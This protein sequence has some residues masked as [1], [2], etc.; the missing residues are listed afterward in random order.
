MTRVGI[1]G[2][3][4]MGNNFRKKIE[5]GVWV[6]EPWEIMGISDTD[7]SKAEGLPYPFF[8]LADDLL[9]ESPDLVIVASPAPSHFELAQEVLERGIHLLVEKP[10][11]LTGEEADTLLAISLKKGQVAAVD[12]P[13]RYSPVIPLAKETM[14]A[15]DLTPNYVNVGWVKD[16]T[17]DNRSHA[18]VLLEEATH[19]WDLLDH[20]LLTADDARISHTVQLHYP[21]GSDDYETGVL[22]SAE[23]GNIQVSVEASFRAI[24]SKRHFSIYCDSSSG[25]PYCLFL[26]FDKQSNG[27][28]VDRL[29]VQ[30]DGNLHQFEN[31]FLVY[32]NGQF[33]EY[34]SDKLRDQVIA[35]D[36]WM[37]GGYP[38]PR[39]CTLEQGAHNVKLMNVILNQSKAKNQYFKPDF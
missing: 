15:L 31:G 24:P 23:Y 10:L 37:T 22:C 8:N 36:R 4:S 5:Q 13:I 35:V 9:R 12:Y 30:V 20:V 14:N 25:K 28:I 19:P 3:G 39:I 38:D 16:R 18:G 32:K 21:R 29:G 27:E 6:G 17:R 7:R 2:H 26:G 1:V 34:K 11:T 33:G